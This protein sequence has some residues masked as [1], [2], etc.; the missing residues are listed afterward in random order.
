MRESQTNNAFAESI[1]TLIPDTLLNSFS[2][3]AARRE[4]EREL[5]YDALKALK[6]IRF[7][8]LRLP[9]A[10]GGLGA[11]MQDMLAMVFKI[12]KADSNIAHIWRNHFMLSERLAQR[13][14]TPLLSRLCESVAQ[15]AIIGLAGPEATGNQS[16]ASSLVQTETG[17][18]FTARKAYSTGSLFADWIVTYAQLPD[19]TNVN[20]VLPRDRHGITLLDDWDGMGQRLT[21]SGTTIFD[22]VEILDEEVIHPSDI[23]PKLQFCTSTLAQVFLTTVVAGITGAIADDATKILG[24]RT[25]TFYFAPTEHAREDPLLLSALGERISEAFAAEAIVT[26]TA[27]SLDVALAA[28][29]AGLEAARET[30]AASLAAAKAKVAVDAIAQR[31]GSGLYDVAG[32]SATLRSLNLDRHWRNLRTVIS[33]NPSSYKSWAI[34]NNILNGVPLP[35]RGIF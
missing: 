10:S 19:G 23:H 25:R 33:H 2:K 13:P 34:G 28:I 21:G 32:A 16:S 4:T 18:R 24:N 6:D 3:E 26:A 5:P 30:Q 20:I 35:E 27:K 7:G 1:E 22:N 8:R 17:W 14:T 15:G 29:D 31:A 12:A 11:S 9:V